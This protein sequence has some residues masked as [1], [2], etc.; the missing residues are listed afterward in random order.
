MVVSPSE[1]SDTI[2]GAKVQLG[3]ASENA[4]VAAGRNGSAWRGVPASV[5]QGS[6]SDVGQSP[7]TRT[8]ARWSVDNGASKGAPGSSVLAPALLQSAGPAEGIPAP[9]PSPQLQPSSRRSDESG[10]KARKS[11]FTK[12]RSPEP[13]NFQSPPERHV[14][15]SDSGGAARPLLPA[16]ASQ[17]PPVSP[18]TGAKSAPNFVEEL[19]GKLFNSFE[20]CTSITA[21]EFEE[22][23]DTPTPKTASALRPA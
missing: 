18:L 3:E 19:V 1:K 20:F 16:G 7:S 4:S 23:V 6:P 2:L 9:V 10:S 21:Y 12:N 13:Y 22:A 14:R 11:G 17:V 15:W 5:Q 8:T